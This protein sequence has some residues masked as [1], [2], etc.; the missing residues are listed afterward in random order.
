V[1]SVLGSAQQR[2]WLR[3]FRVL[4]G[5]AFRVAPRETTLVW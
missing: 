5:F 2:Q 3:A 1:I 4:L